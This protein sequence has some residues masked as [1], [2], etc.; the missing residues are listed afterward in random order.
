MVRRLVRFAS[1]AP[2]MQ[3]FYPMTPLPDAWHRASVKELSRI[4]RVA[5]PKI[6]SWIKSGELTARN[7]GTDPTKRPIYR[8]DRADFDAFWSGRATTA[9]RV[10]SKRR[11]AQSANVKSFV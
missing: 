6:L 3:R 2:C 5:P 8:I 11:R 10:P 4:L 9:P 7:I 1:A